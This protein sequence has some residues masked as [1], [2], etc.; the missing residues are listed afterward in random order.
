MPIPIG[1]TFWRCPTCK[2]HATIDGGEL[3]TVGTPYCG[4]CEEQE[5]EQLEAPTPTILHLDDGEDRTFVGVALRPHGVSIKRFKARIAKLWR[6]FLDTPQPL[7]S[8]G[9]WLEREH[10]ILFLQ[11]EC[12]DVQVGGDTD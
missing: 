8:F 4:K 6:R 3:A 10:G 11:A 9:E 12:L 1:T 7:P 5:M 2:H